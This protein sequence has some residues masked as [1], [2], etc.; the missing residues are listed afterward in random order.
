MAVK[1]LYPCFLVLI[2]VA[3]CASPSTR[4][5][6]NPTLFKSFPAKAQ[7]EI[8]NGKISVGFSPQMVEMAW[9]RPS[10]KLTEQT[11]DGRKEIWIYSTTETRTA[12]VDPYNN[13]RHGVPTIRRS[14]RSSIY[15]GLPP[16]VRMQQRVER[17]R[18]IFA[19]D[20]VERI[21]QQSN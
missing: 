1:I 14:S 5:E 6:K 4:I 21:L 16:T 12:Y 18:V 11:A 7:T 3:G 10:R 2:L 15:G 19:G 13:Y 20:R 17:G 9:G 8:E